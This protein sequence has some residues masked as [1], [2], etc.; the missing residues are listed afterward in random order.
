[1]EINCLPF[2]SVPAHNFIAKIYQRRGDDVMTLFSRR[3]PG[4]CIWRLSTKYF[5]IADNE[6]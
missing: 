2:S 5:S 4:G 1:M 6:K 3:V